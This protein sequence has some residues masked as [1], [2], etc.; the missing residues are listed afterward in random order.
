MICSS[1]SCSSGTGLGDSVIRSVALAVLGVYNVAPWIFTSADGMAL[2]S[3]G[4]QT[5]DDLSAVADERRL[6]RIRVNVDKALR[7]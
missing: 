3:F 4:I 5:A 1:R 6:A 2:V 7:A